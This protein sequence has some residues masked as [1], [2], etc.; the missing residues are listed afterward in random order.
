MLK[1]FIIA[2]LIANSVSILIDVFTIGFSELTYYKLI[3]CGWI[4]ANLAAV[5]KIEGLESDNKIL[6]DHINDIINAVKEP[7]K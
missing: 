5:S 2:G 3:C 4:A 1:Y 7:K 6:S